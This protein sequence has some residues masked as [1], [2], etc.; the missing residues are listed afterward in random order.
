[1]NT[2]NKSDD[3]IDNFSDNYDDG[4]FN[5]K[6][7]KSKNI[8]SVKNDIEAATKGVTKRISLMSANKKETSNSNN[9]ESI[10]DV[11]NDNDWGGNSVS[12]SKNTIDQPMAK[13]FTPL[14]KKESDNQIN[15]RS[16]PVPAAAAPRFD[17][18]N[19]R[20]DNESPDG[21]SYINSQ[22]K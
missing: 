1:M 5:D 11:Y 20:N 12:Q 4:F 22:I 14:S 6:S 16:K 7:E 13:V 21:D 3:S 8:E 19:F 9:E 10:N 18:L 15:S 17:Y 2:V